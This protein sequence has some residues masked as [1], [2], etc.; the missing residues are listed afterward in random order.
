MTSSC[1]II[2]M[3]CSLLMVI[4]YNKVPH[5]PSNF[6]HNPLQTPSLT[7]FILAPFFFMTSSSTMSCRLLL[8]LI[9]SDV[10]SHS[11][12]FPSH[13]LQIPS[14]TLFILDYFLFMTNPSTSCRHRLIK[15]ACSMSK[16]IHSD[17][18][19]HIPSKFPHS[20]S[21]S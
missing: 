17:K 7:L 20:P 15:I 3:A 5:I 1:T 8:I 11:L 4:P 18:F 12:Q 6:P 14:L 19:P 9:H 21:L 13:S 10:P 2:N 16:V